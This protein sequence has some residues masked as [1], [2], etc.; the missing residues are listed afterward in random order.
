[1]PAT[2]FVVGERV[3]RHPELIRRA[4]DMGH[5]I[6]NHSHT[7]SLR[8]HFRHAARPA[9]GDSRLQRRDPLGDRP[10]AS[11]VSLAAGS[12]GA[13]PGRC[14][15]RVRDGRDRLAGAR[16]GLP[17]PGS[18]ANR[19]PHRGGRRRRRRAPASRRRRLAGKHGPLG[20]DSSPPAGDRWP[21]RARLHVPA[22][23]S[24]VRGGRLPPPR[25]RGGNPTARWAGW[26]ASGP[27]R[28]FRDESDGGEPRAERGAGGRRARAGRRRSSAAGESSA[29]GWP[30]RCSGSASWRSACWPCRCCDSSPGGGRTGREEF[31]CSFTTRSGCSPGSW[32]RS[33]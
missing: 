5:V 20:Y 8:F 28:E 30:S 27:G 4:H 26:R 18:G 32:R 21:A 17:A 3:E 10:G 23:G 33:A 29:R 11:S 6:G 9:T 13:G 19:A 2:F 25:L 7:H 14:P 24:A 22:R 1:M 12:Q 31:S 16:D 15:A